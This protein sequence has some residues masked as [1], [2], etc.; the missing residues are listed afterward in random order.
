MAEGRI[1]LVDDDDSV[2]ITV[3]AVLESDGYDVTSVGQGMAALALLQTSSYDLVLTD[4]RMEDVDG[5]MVLAEVKRVAP[6]TVTVMLTGYASLESAVKSLQHGAY[7]YLIKPCNVEEL[8]A[9][10]SRGLERRRLTRQ[11]RERVLDLERANVT[12]QHLNVSLQQRVE[13]ATAQLTS[14][15]VELEQAKDEIAA[16][17]AAAQDNVERLQEYDRLKSQFLSM[18]SHELKTPLTSISGYLQL[19]LKRAQRRLARGHPTADEWEKETQL[20]IKDAEILN[21]QTRR[22][23]RLVNEL[24]D[25]SRIQTGR[26]EY[27]LD[28][29]DLE[30]LAQ[31]VVARAQ[32]T[33]TS[34]QLEVA[35]A[36]KGDVVVEGD[37]DHIEQV[38]NNLVDNAVKYS[39][40]GGTITVSFGEEA[41]KVAVCV[42]DEGLGISPEQ[43]AAIFELFYRSPGAKTQHAGGMGLGLYISSEIVKRHGGEIRVES[44]PG[45]GSTFRVL[46]PRLAGGA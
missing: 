29:V 13:A 18:A 17:Y 44:S 2:R 5:L 27:R 10:I 21:Q 42:K 46:L 33:T 38:L 40:A 43:Q 36:G 31:Q 25:V 32:V 23:S 11:L 24:L 37:R 14:R 19:T 7:A 12:I 9:T 28:P 16:L 45:S 3:Q 35:P 6:E 39:P 34:H 4:L 20:D 15:M 8:Q 26:V 41:G 30:E 22:L 1:L